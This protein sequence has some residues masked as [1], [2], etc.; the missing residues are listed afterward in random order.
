M[1]ARARPLIVLGVLIGLTI[2]LAAAAFDGARRTDSALGRLRDKTSASDAALFATQVELLDPDWTTLVHRPEVERLARWGLA[3]GNV[4][5]REGDLFFVPMDGVW[6]QEIDRPIVISGRMFDPRVADEAVLSDDASKVLGLGVGDTIPFT[7]MAADGT[8]DAPA[9]GPALDVRV[10]GI[11]HTAL[12]YVFT[13][14][15]FLSP[16]FVTQFGDDAFIAENAVVRLHRGADEMAALRRDV[17]VDVGNGV[18]VLDFRVTGRRVTATTDVEGAM[19]RL[20]ATIVSLAGLGFLGQALARS[21]STIGTDVGPLRAFGMT[22]RQ[23]VGAALRPHLLTTGVSV[24]FTAVTVVVASRWFPVGLAAGVDPDRGIQVGVAV[25]IAATVIAALL[26]LGVAAF[27]SWRATRSAVGRDVPRGAWLARWNVARSVPLRMGARMAFEGGGSPR[28]ASAWPALVGAA[29]AV[30]GV[31]AIITV[32]HGLTDALAHPEVAGVA[33][34]ASII[35]HQDDI[36]LAGGISANLVDSVVARPG[37]AA[38]SSIGRVVTEIGELGVPVYTVIEPPTGAA[39][40]LVT[41]SGR[42]PRNDDEIE[43][44]PSTARDLGVDIGDTVHLAD[45]GNARVVG[46]GL[47]PADVHSQFD[48]GAWVSPKRWRGL[49]AIAVDADSNAAVEMLVA[50]R[51]TEHDD[52]EAQIGALQAD[53]GSST[54]FVTPVEQPYEL[55]NLR[56]VRTLP[57]LLAVF[58]AV[59]GSLAV[60]HALFSSVYRRRRDFAVL[61][62]LGVTRTGVRGMIATYATVVALAGLV[63]G[64]PIGLIAGRAGWQAITDRVPLTFRSPLTA[65]A[66]VLVVPIAVITVNAIAVIPARRAAKLKPALVLRSE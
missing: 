16:G 24:A 51:F 64:V 35:P 58:L 19:L 60:G 31:V 4:D 7:A 14:G 54:D 21:A 28:R 8:F 5:G 25:L 1:R 52:L 27:G 39:V 20:L 6:L 41:L 56:N 46:L 9:S 65:L 38:V 57:T 34:D 22:R 18:P 47:F 26:T 10:V 62:S 12:S 42:A 17:N 3:F 2:G 66:V 37:V 40:E 43:L 36:S 13:G 63:L 50:V 23:L 53:F 29:A 45:A 33:W 32:N 11:V 15:A 59:L 30:T 49:S 55:A 44:G 61:Q 48:E